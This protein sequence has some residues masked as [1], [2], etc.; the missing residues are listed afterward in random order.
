MKKKCFLSNNMLKV[1]AAISMLV[2]H[3]GY[4][5]FPRIAIFRI[6]GRLAFPI[7]AYMIAEGCRHTRHRWRYL[8]TM[9]SIG[10]VCQVVYFMFI[11]RV[12]MNIL[13]T[14][15]VSVV[16]I[17]SLQYAKSQFV[18]NGYVLRKILSCI[19]FVVLVVITYIAMYYIRFD[20]GFLGAMLPVFVSAFHSV[21]E[22]KFVLDSKIVHILSFSIGLV[23]MCLFS[24]I[25]YM[26]YSL[27]SIPLLVLYSGSRGKL[28]MKYFFYL[29]YPLH[30][31]LLYGIAMLI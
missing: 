3:I 5:F 31:A 12:Y 30:L 13:I 24:D 9:L 21:G 18:Q 8:L 1:I 23:L 29:F 25:A 20:Y 16:L 4:I 17:Y 28:R 14:F 11:P 22:T 10:I 26:Y 6:I 7:F 2:D 19:V 27:L 15:S